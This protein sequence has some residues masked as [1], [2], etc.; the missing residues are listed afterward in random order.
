[1]R[2]HNRYSRPAKVTSAKE[3]EMLSDQ[4]PRYLE[5]TQDQGAI[6]ETDNRPKLE[7]GHICRDTERENEGNFPKSQGKGLPQLSH[8]KKQGASDLFEGMGKQGWTTLSQMGREDSCR[9]NKEGMTID[10]RSEKSKGL[11]RSR[12]RGNLAWGMGQEVEAY[13]QKSEKL[14]HR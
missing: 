3:S 12:K 7:G 14:G 6:P 4:G 9:W 13:M 11:N 5:I 1:V 10:R 2:E 8:I